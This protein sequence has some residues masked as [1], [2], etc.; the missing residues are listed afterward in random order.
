MAP[1][2]P[3]LAAAPAAAFAAAALAAAAAA[4]AAFATFPAAAPAILLRA[5]ALFHSGS[6]APLPPLHRHLAC[7][8]A[9]AP[10]HVLP[11]GAIARSVHAPVRQAWTAVWAQ[12]PVADSPQ[13]SP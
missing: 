8:Q 11:G 13:G 12:A 2:A 4:D 3:L 5:A 7:I 10:T 9:V 6:T 1:K